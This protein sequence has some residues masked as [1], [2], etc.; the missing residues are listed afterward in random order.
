MSDLSGRGVQHC[1]DHSEL[2]V[3]MC[4]LGPLWEEY[5]IVGDVVVRYFIYC[6]IFV[7]FL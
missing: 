5:G 3:H 1:Q 7:F 4:E 2:L 6:V